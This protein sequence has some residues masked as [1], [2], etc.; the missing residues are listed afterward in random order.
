MFLKKL[1]I[2]LP[3]DPSILLDRCPKDAPLCHRDTCSTMLIAAL[4]VI[5]RNWKQPRCFSTEEWMEK[6]WYVY[7]MECYLTIKNKD[8]RQA[9]G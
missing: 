9:N 7:T 3:L 1:G 4:L 2:A 5:V 6:M 8:I